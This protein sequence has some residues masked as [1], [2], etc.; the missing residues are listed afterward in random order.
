MA[1]QSLAFVVRV[2]GV[3]VR[4]ARPPQGL[5]VLKIGSDLNSDVSLVAREIMRTHA[6]IKVS[7]E[8]DGLMLV[9][10]HHN[11]QTTLNE[12]SINRAS[13][14]DGDIIGIGSF[15]IHVLVNPNEGDLPKVG[16]VDPAKTTQTDD[17]PA[18]SDSPAESGLPKFEDRPHF[19]RRRPPLCLPDRPKAPTS[20]PSREE[21]ASLLSNQVGGQIGSLAIERSALR[22]ALGAIIEVAATNLA[23]DVNRPN[24]SMLEIIQI[25]SKALTSDPLDTA[26]NKLVEALKGMLPKK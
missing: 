4:I 1:I 14:T 26:V 7:A 23:G 11:P 3:V 21:I 24:V 9:D 25:A 12:K 8:S 17:V 10:L 18:T 6:K 16:D 2:D 13:V 5:K 20:A 19:I 22:A 15:R